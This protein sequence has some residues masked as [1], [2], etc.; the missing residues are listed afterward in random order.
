MNGADRACIGRLR[1]TLTLSLLFAACVS[2][3]A[4]GAISDDLLSRISAK[5]REWENRGALGMAMR[6]EVARGEGA[7]GTSWIVCDVRAGGAA[8]LAGVRV[9]DRILRV[10]DAE[11]PT[12]SERAGL[13]VLEGIRAD[14]RTRLALVRDSAPVEVVLIPQRAS[15]E[16]LRAWIFAWLATTEGNEVAKE[17]AASLEESNTRD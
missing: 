12:S 14:A 9:G 10:D 3:S 1:A 13:A 16:M 8:E 5:Q 7:V 11:L 2:A 6:L 4:A 15:T 17:W